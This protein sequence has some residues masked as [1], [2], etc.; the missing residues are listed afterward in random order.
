MIVEFS[1]LFLK[2]LDKITQPQIKANISSIIDQITK[3]LTLSEIH[4]IKKLKGH[5]QTYRIR[6]GD[7]RIGINV[8]NNVVGFGRVAHRKDIYKIFP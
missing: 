8:E 4:N 2:D 7:Y 3:A 1:R 5:N 6:S